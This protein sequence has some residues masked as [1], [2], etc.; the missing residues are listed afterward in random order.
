MELLIALLPKS[1]PLHLETWSIDEA[2]AQLT[3]CVTSMQPRG[4]CPVCRCATRRIHSRY[5]RTVADLP[6]AHF[7]VRLQVRVRKF[8]CANP[9][10]SRRIF[11][12]RL[13]Q[14]V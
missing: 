8:F 4:Y 10:C 12:E 9:R 14:V 2:T 13:P 3:M 6:W 7:R 11:T 5:A 1:P